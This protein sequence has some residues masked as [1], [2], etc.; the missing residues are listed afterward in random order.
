VRQTVNLDAES[1]EQLETLAQEQNVSKSQ[2][3]R[4]ALDHYDTVSRKWQSVDREALEWYVKLLGSKEHRII[5]VDHINA[6]LD[7][8]GSPS[9]ELL[10]E[11]ERIGHKHGIEWSRQFDSVEKKLRVLEYCNWY[12]ITTLSEGQFALTTESE[13]EAALICSFLRGEC[14]ELELDVEMRQVDQKILVTDNSA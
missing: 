5:D 13:A 14:E 11:W 3:I 12:T 8:L 9:E 2:V 4:D 1:Q 7:E 6:F 10:A